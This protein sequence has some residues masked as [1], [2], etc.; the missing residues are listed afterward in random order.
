MSGVRD[1]AARA[2]VLVHDPRQVDRVVAVVAF[3]GAWWNAAIEPHRDLGVLAVVALAVLMGTIA[4]RRVNPIA[5]T[6][7]AA[8]AL[9]VFQAVSLYNG[10]GTFEA[11]A[12]AFS[13][14]ILGQ[15]TRSRPRVLWCAACLAVWSGTAW[16]I[17]FDPGPGSIG[18]MVGAWAL[19]GPLPFACGFLLAARSLLT[20]DL[21]HRFALLDTEQEHRS[22]L[23]AGEERNRMARELHDVIAHCLSVM[24][25]QVGGARTVAAADPQRASAALQAVESAGREALADLRR[26]VGALRRGDEQGGASRP[27]LGDVEV[28]VDRARRAGLEVGVHLSGP[29]ASLTPAVN[30]VAYRV[31][32]EALTNC[33][34][35]AGPARADVSAR[36]HGACLRIAVTDTGCGGPRCANPVPGSGRGLIGMQERVSSLDGELRAG[37]RPEG[38]FEVR[39][40]IPLHG[41]VEP[42]EPAAGSDVA[43]P[44]SAG[45]GSRWP[46]HDLVFAGALMALLET[47]VLTSSDVRGP[48]GLN[49]LAV[50][51]FAIAALWRRRYPLLFVLV[52]NVIGGI[53]SVTLTPV[54]DLAIAAALYLLVLPYTVAAWANR[55]RA[56]L[57]LGLVLALAVA[58]HL[59]SRT[60][61]PADLAGAA[62]IA[63]AAWGLGLAVRAGRAKNATLWRVLCRLAAESEDRTRLVVAGERSRLARELHE[64]LAGSVSVM[65]VQAEVARAHLTED[66][67]SADQAMTAVE[68]TGRQAL[69]DMRH[70]LGALR[71]GEATADRQP[72]P[73][74]DQVY[75]LVR[76]ARDSGQ[77]IE[78]RVEGE[79][80]DI[81]AT[82]EL[83]VYRVLE[84]ALRDTRSRGETRVD[85]CLV[86]GDRDLELHLTAELSGT[87]RWPTSTMRERIALCGGQIDAAR[88]GKD[89]WQLAVRMPCAA[90]GALL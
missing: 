90:D 29:V 38:G 55:F 48:L 68:Q 34:K 14:Y 49:V 85:L 9:A 72:L 61:T 24:V 69:A 36:V 31:V 27:G 67:S 88:P 32:Q 5:S 12:I 8:V 26:L 76:E 70:I 1:W 78:L 3:A 86:F 44:P 82:V 45:E 75:A 56:V 50:S 59:A 11:A 80:G 54:R 15:R 41:A 87:N 22:R 18:S 39:A 53:M 6:I 25:V 35:H 28:L 20:A 63:G 66:P 81:P 42:D 33:I 2:R 40:R 37:P 4:W 62:V 89:E 30:A 19:F 47:A 13:F 52:V 7:V 46:W 16:L 84:E 73:G 77:R 51:G 74:I 83:G 43:R 65:V 17:T 57:G 64:S 71:R 79:P 58:D 10:D 60:G 23:A 21:Q